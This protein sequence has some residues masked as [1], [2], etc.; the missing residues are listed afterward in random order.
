MRRESK[1]VREAWTAHVEG[2]AA[3][4]EAKYGN[5]RT[6]NYASGHEAAV[7][8]DL[9]ALERGGKIYELREQVKF[10]LVEGNGKL[11]PIRYIADFVWIDED[12]RTV[13]GDAKGYS[14]NQVWRLKQKMMKLLLGIEVRVL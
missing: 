4:P 5:E 9:A 2:R 6:G 1:A 3:A 11:R 8:A 12:G 14:K 7:A 10:T 13:V